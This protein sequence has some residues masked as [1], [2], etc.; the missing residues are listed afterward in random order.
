MN[1]QPARGVD[2]DALLDQDPLW[3][4]SRDAVE[5]SEEGLNATRALVKEVGFAVPVFK[6]G[7]VDLVYQFAR[8]V[9]DACRTSGVDRGE[10]AKRDRKVEELS[11]KVQFS[12]DNSEKVT[13]LQAQVTGKDVALTAARVASSWSAKMLDAMTHVYASLRSELDSLHAT[14]GRREG[15]LCDFIERVCTVYSGLVRVHAASY[16]N[17]LNN[18]SSDAQSRGEYVAGYRIRVGEGSYFL[19]IDEAISDEKQGNSPSTHRSRGDDLVEV[20]VPLSKNQPG[21]S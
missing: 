10:M 9:K 8:V 18:L 20:V 16:S 12:V 4:Q 19:S 3:A 15:V 11:L 2:L 7:Y 5:L 17:Q 6:K 1:P 14:R 13:W 21:A